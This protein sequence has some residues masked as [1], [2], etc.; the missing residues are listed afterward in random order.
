MTTDSN[1]GDSSLAGSKAR[2]V[3]PN[4][5]KFNGL[6]WTVF[7]LLR[8]IRSGSDALLALKVLDMILD[9]D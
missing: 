5:S 7:S 9:A 8:M 1:E 4:G 3:D 6:L 2:F